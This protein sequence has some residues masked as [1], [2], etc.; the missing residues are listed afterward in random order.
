[1]RQ[2]KMAVIGAGV[3]GENHAMALST[4]PLVELALIC[5]LNADRATGLILATA[6]LGSP[7]QAG[8]TRLGS[9]C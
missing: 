6:P 4:Y 7:D 2:V 8:G 5:D 3:W 9:Y 1:M